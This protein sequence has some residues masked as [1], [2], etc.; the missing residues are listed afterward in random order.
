LEEIGF[1]KVSTAYRVICKSGRLRNRHLVLKMVCLPL[2]VQLSD[3]GPLPQVSSTSVQPH[4]NKSPSIH[5]ALHHPNIVAMF[6]A[7][8]TSSESFH[9]LELCSMGS[10]S[11]FLLDRLPSTLLE[12][13]LRG[14]VKSLVDALVYL[15]KEFVIHCNITPSKIF[16]TDNYGVVSVDV[17]IRQTRSSSDWLRNCPALNMRSAL[18]LQY[19]VQQ[20]YDVQAIHSIPHRKHI[21][22]FVFTLAHRTKRDRIWDAFQLPRRYMVS[23]VCDDRVCIGSTPF[24]CTYTPSCAFCIY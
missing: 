17:T 3:N 9:V 20:I 18:R 10:L 13:E 8:Y 22:S 14:V 24:R 12:T 19:Q 5:T 15:R 4:L 16:L 7:F 11:E 6:S 23:R 1:G 21:P 2:L